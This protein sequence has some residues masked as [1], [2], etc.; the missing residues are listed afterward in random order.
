MAPD[1]ESLQRFQR[2]AQAAA[3][4]N[5]PNIVTVHD[6]GQEDGILYMAMELL[7]GRTSATPS[8][9]TS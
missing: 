3:L 5:H 1:E 4:L 7:E 8:T 6:Y 2:E 9:R